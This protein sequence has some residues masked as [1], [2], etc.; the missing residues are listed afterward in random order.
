M[1]DLFSPDYALECKL[2]S[3]HKTDFRRQRD[4]VLEVLRASG[5]LTMQELADRLKIERTSVCGRLNELSGLVE[6]DGTRL[7]A[8]SGKRNALYRAI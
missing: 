8:R 2:E 7:N 6:E 1:T 4:M 3:W 5:P